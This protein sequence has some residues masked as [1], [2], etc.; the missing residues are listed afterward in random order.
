MWTCLEVGAIPLS[1]V[2]VPTIQFKEHHKIKISSATVQQK[3]PGLLHQTGQ[4][5]QGLPEPT[6]KPGVVL[7]EVKI[8]KDARPMK[9]CTASYTS[10]RTLSVFILLTL[11][12]NIVC[13]LMGRLQ[14]SFTWH[15]QTFP[16]QVLL[17]TNHRSNP[18]P[19]PSPS[20]HPHY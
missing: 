8:S 2:R 11:S 15:K 5:Q 19:I 14:K 16:P 17:S 9:C 13:P 7:K 12:T 10:F 1:D 18:Y 6:R 3:Q 4:S 20:S